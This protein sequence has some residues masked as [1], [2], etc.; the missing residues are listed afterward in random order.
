MI[1][2]QAYDHSEVELLRHTVIYFTDSAAYGGAEQAMLTL[3]AGLDRKHWHPVLAHHPEPGLEHLSRLAQGLGVELWVVPRMGGRY[4]VIRMVRFAQALRIR[5]PAVFHAHLNWPLACRYGLVAA[6]LARIPAVV[7]T[8][9]LFSDVPWR[10][11]V[12]VQRLLSTRIDRYV[13]V[14]DDMARRLRAT[15]RL[16]ARGVPVVRNGICLARYHRP[17]NN[18]LR[19][20]WWGGKEEPIIL[21]AAR[22]DLQKGH[23]YLLQAAVLVPKARFVLAGD[24]PLR[25]MLEAQAAALGVADR[26][27]FLGQRDD[28]PALLASCDL[29]VLPSL[30]E[31]LPLS[32]LE[33][34]AAGKPII[35]TMIGGTNEA[36][37]HGENGILVPPADPVALAAAIRTLLADPALAR[38]MA[39]AGEFRARKE[40]DASVMVERVTGIYNELLR[41]RR[42]PHAHA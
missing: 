32:I 22:L 21:T 28:V 17:P 38:R 9:H 26:I 12:Y 4:A 10:R 37:R 3:M 11:S 2:S 16:P 31:G 8:V 39:V 33:A 5:Q 14:S 7:A 29:F 6:A 27:V 25:G 36:I 20:V 19:D 18:G 1:Y 15:F 34:M 41:S 23:S 24:G 42:V 30:F 13:A 40:F 35:A